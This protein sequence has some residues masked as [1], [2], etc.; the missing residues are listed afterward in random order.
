MLEDE[1][2]S[3]RVLVSEN[4]SHLK[5]EKFTFELVTIKTQKKK[6]VSL[7][8]KNLGSMSKVCCIDAFATKVQIECHQEHYIEC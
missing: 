1:K 3:M 6:G 8:T 5:A 4:L 7:G 2:F